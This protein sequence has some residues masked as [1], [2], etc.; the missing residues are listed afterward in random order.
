MSDDYSRKCKCKH[1]IEQM[2]LRNIRDMLQSMGKDIR[3]FPLPEIDEKH[4]TTNGIP[5]F[6]IPLRID[7][8]AICGFTKESGTA[9]LLQAASLII[10]DEASMTK[11]Q[12]LRR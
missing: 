6:K 8:G 11:R 10:W 4:D 5:R 2:V 3:L 1:T 7:D 12:E 9:K